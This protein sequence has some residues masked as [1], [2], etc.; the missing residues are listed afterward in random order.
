MSV[1]GTERIQRMLQGNSTDRIPYSFWTHFPGIDLDPDKLADMTYQLYK[2]L[3]MDF[4]KHM[5]NGLYSVEDFG[6]ECDYSDII[7]GGVAKIGKYAINKPNNWNHIPILNIENGAYGREIRSLERLL[8]QVKGSTPILATVFN[9]LTT[10]FKMSG[11]ALILHMREH[12]DKVKNG[13]ESI[14]EVTIRFA[15]KVLDKGCVG[16]FLA[17]QMA[18]KRLLTEEEF[19]EFVVPYDMKLLQAIERKSWFNIM[20][21]HGN[22]TYFSLMSDYPVHAF[23][24]HIWE[25]APTIQEFLNDPKLKNKIIVGGLQRFHITDGRM[26]DLKEQIADM[27]RLTKGEKL[28][29]APGCGIRYPFDEQTLQEL[30]GEIISSGQTT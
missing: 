1:T 28:V 5:P 24:W 8:G 19:Q 13:L 26:A 3:D 7:F 23:N 15:E 10:A 30:R 21:V 20:H 17:N 14:T 16:I 12:P 11:Q 29:L 27:I 6:C 4:I 9:P 25:T 18:V 22:D 2:N